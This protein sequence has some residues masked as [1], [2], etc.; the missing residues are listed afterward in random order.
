MRGQGNSLL[1][2]FQDIALLPSR[3]CFSPHYL[4]IA[5]EMKASGPPHV[6]KMWLVVS[7]GI[8]SVEYFHSNK[9]FVSVEFHGDH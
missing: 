1:M 2:D 4:K 8:L 9:A 5:V 7:K 3:A 6:L